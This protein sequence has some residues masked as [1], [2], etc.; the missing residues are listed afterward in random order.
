MISINKN[1]S[2]RHV[3]GRNGRIRIGNGLNY[4]LNHAPLPEIHLLDGMKRYKFCGPWTDLEKRVVLDN[5]GNLVDVITPPINK[6][7]AACMSHDIFYN[8]YKKIPERNL[9]DEDLLNEAEKVLYDP[10]SNKKD[11]WNA[12]LVKNIMKLKIN[13]KI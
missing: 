10:E 4:F 13:N 1:N 9:A 11:K 6:L 5:D 12:Y 3:R 8:K 7:D 2:K